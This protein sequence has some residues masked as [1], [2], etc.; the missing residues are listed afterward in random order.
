MKLP[1]VLYDLHLTSSYFWDLFRDPNEKSFKE[2][3]SFLE[4]LSPIV[5]LKQTESGFGYTIKRS[6]YT[7][8]SVYLRGAINSK[9]LHKAHERSFLHPWWLRG[10]LLGLHQLPA[11]WNH[12]DS[13]ALRQGELRVSG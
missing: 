9:R 1:C 11:S 12:H 7:A 8:Y 5:P 4:A 3:S 10:G 6:P 2:F 13:G